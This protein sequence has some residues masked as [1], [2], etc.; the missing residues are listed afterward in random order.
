MRFLTVSRAETGE[1]AG[2][3]VAVLPLS[4]A[5]APAKTVASSDVKS[6]G[7]KTRISPPSPVPNAASSPAVPGFTVSGLAASPEWCANG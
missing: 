4:Q 6:H 3:A 7:P 2:V 5:L 1:G